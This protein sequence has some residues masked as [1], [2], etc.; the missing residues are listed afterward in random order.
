MWDFHGA[1]G[2]TEAWKA[3]ELL[4][5]RRK[6]EHSLRGVLHSIMATL[7]EMARCRS[8]PLHLR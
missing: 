1:D 5:V 4:K 6:L 2:Q 8:G 7:T 3:G